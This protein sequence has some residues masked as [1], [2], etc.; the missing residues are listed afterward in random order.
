MANSPSLVGPARDNA[1]RG[2][3]AVHDHVCGIYETR[4]EMY[5]AAA[6]FLKAGLAR[7]EQCMYI[8]ERV[9]PAE[10][11]GVL[12]AQGCNANEA[13]S[14]GSLVV[15]SG[16]EMR[17]TLGGFSIEAMKSFL[18][19]AETKALASGFVGFRWGA[20]MTWLRQDNIT[21]VELFT[22]EAQLNPFLREHQLV[23]F[24]QYAMEDFESELLIAAAETHPLLVYNHT[25]CDN[26]YYVPPEEYLSPGS[27]ETKLK[28]IL[29]NIISR[30]RL[31]QNF[32][33]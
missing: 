31:M 15:V 30:E 1:A 18:I 9:S 14:A 22:F 3:L 7:N 2:E 28:R 32:L 19:G 23:A 4:E 21:P 6:K 12:D 11:L 29:F 20:E 10:F 13:V 5:D 26:F 27:A 8:A 24:C 16:E 33:A 25:V 17:R